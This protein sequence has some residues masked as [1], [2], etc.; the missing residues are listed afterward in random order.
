MWGLLR[1]SRPALG[2]AGGA[3]LCTLGGD[4]LRRTDSLAA[5]KA[6]SEAARG[7]W[8]SPASSLP[9]FTQKE[10]SAHTSIEKGLWVTFDGAV[11]DITTFVQNHP[12]GVE[13][14]SMAAG[15]SVEPFW[16][17]YRQ[18]VQDR[19]GSGGSGLAPKEHVAEILAPLQIG[20]LDPADVAAAAASARSPDDPYANEPLRHPALRMLSV[21]P[22]SG[23]SPAALMAD[24]WITPNELFF[25]RNHHPVPKIDGADFRLEVSGLG[26]K[27]TAFT[28]A[29]LMALP[30]TEVTATLQCGGNRRGGLD[31][32]RKSSG[33]AW[34]VGAISNA[35][36]G[37]VRLSTLLQACGLDPAD[38]QVMAQLQH[39]QFEGVDGTKASVPA[40]KAVSIS[41]DVLVAYEM[42]GEPLPA[43]HGYPLRMVVPGHVGVRNIKWL[44]KVKTS[45]E[46]AEG[47]WQRGMAYKSFGPSVTS[48]DGI[49]VGSYAAMQEMPVQSVILSPQPGAKLEPGDEVTVRGLAW[50]G[51]GRGI[52]RVDVSADD[53]ATWQTA[54]LTE[55]ADQARGKAWAWTFWEAE[56]TVADAQSPTRATLVCKALDAAHNSQPES[57]ASIWNLRG[58]ANNSWHRVAVDFTA[59]S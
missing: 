49:D 8:Q 37:G 47:V 43:D 38:P 12:G 58:L 30:K 32:V 21:T 15:S 1:R 28:L 36:W 27:E 25:I 46:E 41:G 13:K 9:T 4:H 59:E 34:G 29:E 3:V 26:V 17:L 56:V 55:G 10:V 50:S 52:I 57:A 20:W 54:T 45:T 22:C 53:G 35:K 16:M 14:I 48:L 51:G 18:H 31:E 40:E 33:N 42:N 39:V 6:P 44:N 24:S 11:Y 19:S 23:E 5:A 2:A 7:P